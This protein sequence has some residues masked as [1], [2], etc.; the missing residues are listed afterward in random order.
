[1][2]AKLYVPTAQIGSAAKENLPPRN[3]KM[4]KGKVSVG[5]LFNQQHHISK[6]AIHNQ[7]SVLAP[8]GGGITKAQRPNGGVFSKF[9]KPKKA[10]EHPAYLSFAGD[11][12]SA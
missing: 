9:T 4:A 3:T 10:T 2:C 1:M 8:R 11:S 7:K 12:D 5:S 6:S